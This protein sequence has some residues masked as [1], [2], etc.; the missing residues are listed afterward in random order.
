MSRYSDQEV[1][2]RSPRSLQEE[3]VDVYWRFLLGAAGALGLALVFTRERAPL[4]WQ[5]AGVLAAL[6]A[7][8]TI[9]V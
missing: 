1:R 4:W 9:T 7:L 3:T 6:V 8:V 5:A 2:S